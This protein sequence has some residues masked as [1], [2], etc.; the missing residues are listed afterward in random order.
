MSKPHRFRFLDDH[1]RPT[2]VEIPGGVTIVKCPP[3]KAPGIDDRPRGRTIRMAAILEDCETRWI[4]GETV[5]L[6]SYLSAV[7]VQRRV[8]ISLGLDRVPR[9]VTPT[10]LGAYLAEKSEETDD[11]D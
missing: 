7:G 5:D 1:V 11:A 4:A 9:D 3:G 2:P 6:G 10:S 8:L